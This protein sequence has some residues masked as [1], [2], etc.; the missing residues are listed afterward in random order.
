MSAVRVAFVFALAIALSPIESDAQCGPM[1]SCAGT[2]A[3]RVPCPGGAPDVQNCHPD[4][5]V[6]V[7][8]DCHPGC[9]DSSLPL[10]SKETKRRF[11][12]IVALAVTADASTVLTAELS[13][14]SGRLYYNRAR[15]AVQLMSCDGSTVIA[16]IPLRS[17]ADRQLA[18][19]RLPP[20]L[21][22]DGGARVATTGTVHAP[23]AAGRR[24][25]AQAVGVANFSR[26]R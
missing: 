25:L 13:S 6:C 24:V 23:A 22:L 3:H 19:L 21:L 18:Q 12:E 4:C 14:P 7:S 15:S 17:G 10:Q 8:G 2:S 9:Q 11:D 20:T 5:L 26:S 1:V 16:S